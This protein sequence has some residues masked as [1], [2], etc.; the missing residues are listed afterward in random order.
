MQVNVI[1]IYQSEV[2]FLSPTVVVALELIKKQR[3]VWQNRFPSICII[4]IDQVMDT[5][6]F[7]DT[8]W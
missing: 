1:M 2:E 6:S 4:V 3:N 8:S 7:M 5:I